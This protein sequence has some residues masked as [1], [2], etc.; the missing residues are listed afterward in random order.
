MK[1]IIIFVLALLFS[2]VQAE[3]YTFA[4]VP[5]QSAKVLAKKWG[6]ILRYVSDKSGYQINFRT[7]PK[8]PVFEQRVSQGDYDFAYMN[9][10]HY[11]VFA[12]NPGYQAF[13]KQKGKKIKGIFVVAK[14]SKIKELSDLKGSTLAFPAPAAFAASVL[15][16]GLLSEQK[17]EFKPKYVGS[18]DSVYMSVA[19]GLY[20][21]GGGIQRTFGTTSP[22]IREKLKVLT[23]TE[24]F[25]PHAFASH[26]RV[27]KE[28]VAAVQKAFVEMFS[29][30]K[31]KELLLNVGFKKGAEK[32]SSSDWD[33]VR[34]LG[35]TELP[36]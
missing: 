3:Q 28:V 27:P 35:Y 34:K 30:A 1:K 23:I 6:P 8:I 14:D 10:V 15:P 13:A 19:R 25:T 21:A 11:T 2:N 33:D 12:E 24:G 29:D 17:I 4:F 26:P 22:A 20:P 5:Q 16:R 18:H 7:A 9:P 31:G 36:K 32:A